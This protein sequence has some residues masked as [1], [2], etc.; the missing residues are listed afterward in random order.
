MVVPVE[1]A[2]ILDDAP[3]MDAAS[4]PAKGAGNAVKRRCG[5]GIGNGWPYRSGK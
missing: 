2:G 3:G 1:I 5:R 4:W